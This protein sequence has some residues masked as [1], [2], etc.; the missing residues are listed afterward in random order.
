MHKRLFVAYSVPRASSN[1]IIKPEQIEPIDEG[2]IEVVRDYDFEGGQVHMKIA[3][4]NKSKMAINNVKV[5]LDAPSNFKIKQPL[6]S[7]PVIESSASRG[8]DF[9]LEP[10][11]CGQSIVGGTLS[12]DWLNFI[13][14]QV[15]NV[16][17]VLQHSLFYKICTDTENQPA[18]LV[19]IL[20]KQ[21]ADLFTKIQISNSR[22]EQI[23]EYWF[24][25]KK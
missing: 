19:S 17:N 11:T 22:I 3:V 6:I 20:G 25:K 5:I 15:K 4:R 23:S 12:Q 1:S 21:Q 24:L 16:L 2:K 8:V 7:I 9:Y 10:K 14:I 13:I 18:K